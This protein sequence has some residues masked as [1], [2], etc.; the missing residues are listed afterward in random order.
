MNKI[1]IAM[2]QKAGFAREDRHQPYVIG[3]YTNP[4]TAMEKYPHMKFETKPQLPCK[5]Y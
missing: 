3:A 1:H 4:Q 2:G 5:L